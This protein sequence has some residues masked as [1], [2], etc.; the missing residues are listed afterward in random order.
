MDRG[1]PDFLLR[2]TPELGT[3]Y[4]GAPERRELLNNI[5]IARSESEA[6]AVKVHTETT[7]TL[8]EAGNP[9]KIGSRNRH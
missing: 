5:L 8:Q 2:P 7:L 3:T 6:R 4:C 9:S 1:Y